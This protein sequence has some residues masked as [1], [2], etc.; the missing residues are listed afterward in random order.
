MNEAFHFVVLGLAVWRLSSLFVNE[1]GP[2]KILESF[3][4]LVGADTDFEDKGF[5]GGIFSCIWCLSMWVS[6]AVVA[7][8]VFFPDLTFILAYLFSL[9][10]VACIIESV[11]GE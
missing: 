6:A 1:E 4:K 11:I 8:Y 10:A 3:R 9:S 5:L 7:G 2:F